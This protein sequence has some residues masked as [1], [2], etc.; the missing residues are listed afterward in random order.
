MQKLTHTAYK[1]T[2]NGSKNKIY[3]QKTLKLLEINKGGKSCPWIW[4]CILRYDI[5]SMK[6][7][8][9][10]D[11]LNFIKNKSFCESK[12]MIKKVKRQSTGGEKIFANHGTD[13]GLVSRIYEEL[14]I[15]QQKDK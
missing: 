6:S 5:K 10:I 12:D 9:K 13:K 14:I 3:E 8:R 1:L 15:Q 7:K 11:K 4:Q 2:Q